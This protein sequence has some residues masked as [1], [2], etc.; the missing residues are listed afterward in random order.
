MLLTGVAT[1]RLAV[2]IDRL[3]QAEPRAR[4]RDGYLVFA[5]TII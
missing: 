5:T 2:R 3:P 1:G 4:Q